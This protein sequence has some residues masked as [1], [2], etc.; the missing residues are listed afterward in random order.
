MSNIKTVKGCDDQGNEYV[1]GLS[2][3]D[4]AITKELLEIEVSGEYRKRGSRRWL[5]VVFTVQ[6][7]PA[8]NIIII[9]YEN[10]TIGSIELRE[11][12][13]GFSEYLDELEGS[14]AW[15]E[16]C[17]YVVPSKTDQVEEVAEDNSIETFID[18]I[19]AA[20]PV[21]GCL[22]KAGLSTTIGQIIRCNAELN[23]SVKEEE[24]IGRRKRIWLI[25]R[26]LGVHTLSMSS[27]FVWRSVRC[28]ITLV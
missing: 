2:L 8:K 13:E 11:F 23:S 10:E 14:K 9:I 15:E 20:E 6:Y 7:N 3:N 16:I 21:F 24:P 28:G 25:L 27:K 19:P 22:I 1:I 17:N 5:H 12:N 26:C 18:G 4:A